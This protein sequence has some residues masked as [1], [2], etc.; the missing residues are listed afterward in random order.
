MATSTKAAEVHQTLWS[1]RSGGCSALRLP[2]DDTIAHIARVYT[3]HELQPLGL[4][5]PL[6]QDIALMVSELATNALR[7]GTQR[8][9]ASQPLP[10]AHAEL[11]IYRRSNA[12]NRENQQ[13]QPELVI[14]VFDTHREKQPQQLRR[15]DTN[16]LDI[17]GFV[18]G[19]RGLDIIHELTGGQWGHHLSRSRLAAPTTLGKAVWIATP[20]PPSSPHTYPP[21]SH[22]DEA[23]AIADLYALLT[24]RGIDRL[25]R[26][27]ERGVSVLS[28]RRNLTVWC[29]AGVFCWRT[30][31]GDTVRLPVGD[32][33]EACEQI[34]QLHEVM[35]SVTQG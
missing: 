14:K 8:S 27:D 22:V 10:S 6:T 23:R 26:R 29:K 34:V 13:A 28:V 4:P 2:A 20:L 33:V 32:I 1:L 25:I 30:P 12:H 3:A 35:S 18:E 19:G 17:D 9:P 11:W 15:N 21:L 24:E 7:H 5:D 16:A 31:A